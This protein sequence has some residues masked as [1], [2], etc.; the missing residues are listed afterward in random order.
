[1]LGSTTRIIHDGTFPPYVSLL[2]GVFVQSLLFLLIYVSRNYPFIFE[3]SGIND[4]PFRGLALYIG[5]FSTFLSQAYIAPPFRLHYRGLGELTSALLLAPM[6][7]LWGLVGHYTASIG[8]IPFSDLFVNA[9]TSKSG[10]YADEQIWTL[11]A[12]FYCFEQGRIFIMHLSDIE[13]DRAGGKNTFCVKAGRSVAS[14]LYLVLNGLCGVFTWMVFKQLS[15]KGGMVFSVA[16]VKPTLENRQYVAMGW[17]TG[18]IVIGSY[19]MPVVLITAKSIFAQT[20][21]KGGN[22]TDKAILRSFP[23]GIP[24]LSGSQCAM[25]VS[26][27]NLVTPAVLSLVLTVTVLIVGG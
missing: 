4:S 26:L 6:S 3:R 16:G 9:S 27:T 1:M 19:A 12:S 11:F 21:A 14:R 20:V 25:M 18:A 15:E 7:F 23:R 17:K 5:L 10:F 2:L 24:V 22:G 8:P 13:K